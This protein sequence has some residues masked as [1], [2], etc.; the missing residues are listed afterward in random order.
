MK[1]LAVSFALMFSASIFQAPAALAQASVQWGCD[2]P[3]RRTCY[4]TIQS[5]GGARSFSLPAG[6]RMIVSGVMPG[7][8]HY[9]VSLD[10]PNLGDVNRCRQLNLM[11]RTCH[12]KT[13]D[14][15]YND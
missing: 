10:A 4:F 15:A 9:Q 13:V 2:A 3:A 6:G 1:S 5:P 7:R 11:G 8:D 14:T 12:I